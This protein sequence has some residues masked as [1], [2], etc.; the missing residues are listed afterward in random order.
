MR[1]PKCHYLS[2]EPE[3]RCKN[4]GYDLSCEPGDLAI[5][6][7][8]EPLADFDL[9]VPGATAPR[10]V[11]EI[12]VRHPA[13]GSEKAFQRVDD[14][15]PAAV[16]SISEPA[17]AAK[18]AR[19]V[20]SSSPK[21]ALTTE[22]P[23]F[24]QGL[25]ESASRTDQNDLLVKLPRAPR[26]PLAVRRPTPAPGR[27][28][29]KYQREVAP[30]RQAG[31]LERDLFDIRPRE[32]APPASPPVLEAPIPA[33][34]RGREVRDLPAGAF[35]R[36]EAACVDVLFIGAIN[37]AVVWLTLQRC[38]LTFAQ[39]FQLPLLPLLAYLFLVDSGYLLLFTATNGQTVGKMAA[40]LRVVGTSTEAISTDHVTLKQ[41]ALRAVLT[42]P[43][44]LALG[45]GFAPALLGK[46]LTLH[47]RFA[48]TRVVR[49]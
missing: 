2:F 41:A 4:C 8:Q 31:L 13:P 48:H 14:R 27:V 35:R 42:F 28:R 9:Q 3:P 37:L 16:A 20:Q 34:T 17:A 7:G 47:D 1:C 18:P 39:A 40:G 10:P 19:P 36:I 12:I 26:A 5:D 15:H 25:T 30:V 45:I 43:S 6:P 33:V 38:D 23:L 44:V 21:A 24:V 22:L 49:A 29:E 32:D 46:G 11:A